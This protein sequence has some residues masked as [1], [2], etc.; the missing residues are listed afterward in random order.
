MLEAEAMV[1]ENLVLNVGTFESSC[2]NSSNNDDDDD[3]D[4]LSYESHLNSMDVPANTK[5]FPF[6]N[7]KFYFVSEV[8]VLIFVICHKFL[9]VFSCRSK[10]RF[11]FVILFLLTC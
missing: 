8:L 5:F 11:F 1:S 3:D 7:F 6:I 10:P 4:N 2:S 9:L